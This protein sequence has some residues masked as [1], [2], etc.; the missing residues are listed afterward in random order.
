MFESREVIKSSTW[1]ELEA[2]RFGLESF[3]NKLSNK[4]VLWMTDNRAAMYVS[5]S[6]SRKLD[7]QDLALSIY[8]L[9]RHYN[10]DL[11]VNWV[12]RENNQTA[13]YFSKLIDS[14]DW[15]ITQGFLEFLEEKWGC[16]SID[17]FANFNNTKC[18]R[19]NSRY[20]VPGTEAVDAFTQDW[21]FEH[22][23]IVPPV[24]SLIRVI[25]V[26]KSQSNI[27]GVIVVPY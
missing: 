25:N 14:D 10:I 2:I 20:L 3:N 21:R 27:K 7:L 26:I 9:T 4:S 17:R 18:E 22:N 15:E 16:F 13:D 6:G 23:L 19:F 8:D 12:P 1:R 5:S 11:E 24:G